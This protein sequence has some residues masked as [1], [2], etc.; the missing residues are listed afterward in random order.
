M[1]FENKDIFQPDYSA[2]SY[3]FIKSKGPNFD[4]AVILYIL[5]LISKPKLYEM[6]KIFIKSK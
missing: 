5:Y 2:L 1:E 4:L 3:V 6:I